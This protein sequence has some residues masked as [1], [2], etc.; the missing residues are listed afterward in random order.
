MTQGHSA[1]YIL[2]SFFLKFIYLFIYLNFKYKSLAVLSRGEDADAC[3]IGEGD[4]KGGT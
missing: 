1:L 3:L 2:P 4:E